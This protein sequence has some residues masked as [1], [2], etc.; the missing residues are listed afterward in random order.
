MLADVVEKVVHRESFKLMYINQDVLSE[1]SK[2]F[3][4]TES[5]QYVTC[6][7]VHDIIMDLVHEWAHSIEIDNDK[8]IA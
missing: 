5:R 3:M 1:Q 4:A 7:G 2:F 6:R 8:H